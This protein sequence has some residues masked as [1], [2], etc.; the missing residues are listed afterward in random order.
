MAP[1]HDKVGH[2]N[3]MTYL[4]PSL[5]QGNVKAYIHHRSKKQ[6]GSMACIDDRSRKCYGIHAS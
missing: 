5:Y 2:G 3:I 6:G 4:H 1:I